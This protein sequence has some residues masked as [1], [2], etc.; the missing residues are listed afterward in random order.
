MNKKI[1]VITPVYNASKTLVRCVESLVFGDYDNLDIILI[2]DCS[3]D[4]S[5]QICNMLSDKYDNVRCFQNEKNS[6]VSYTRNQ[7]LNMAQGEYIL[8]VDSDDWVSGRYAKKLFDTIN[9]H[10]ND[11][12][13]CGLHFIDNVNDYARDYLWENATEEISIVEKK[14]FF[15]LPNEFLLQQLWNKIFRKDIIDKNHIQFDVNQSMGE[16]YQFVLEYMEALQCKRC[17]VINEPLYY[18]IRANNFSLMSK[19]G[20][21][22]NENEYLRIEKLRDICGKEDHDILE[23][24]KRSVEV[25]KN[26]YAYYCVHSKNMSKKEKIDFI[27]SVF[28]DKNSKAYYKKQMK[29]KFKENIINSFGKIKKNSAGLL[30]RAK[31]LKTNYLV[32]KEKS[33]LKVSEISII[34]QNCISGVFY[35]D[36]NIKFLSPTINLYFSCPDFVK[37]VLHMDYY[38]SLSPLMKWEE[39]YPV[40][41]LDDIKINFMHYAT[42]T[43]AKEK[44]EERK[45]R[46]N[47]DKMVI[48]C[49]DMEDFNDD[50]Y[51][52][53]KTIK[54]KKLLFTANK[55]YS[56]NAVFFEKYEIC[57]K[58]KD[59]IPKREFYKDDAI[60]KIINK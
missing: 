17:I 42:C 20:L 55:K 29:I 53:W 38:L 14:D 8:C 18:Y 40:G 33:K 5:W 60:F 52:A 58:V 26:N 24:Y 10:G 35:H 6:G 3:N 1:S 28:K 12:V 32:R 54:Y 39:E 48:L 7:G 31:R 45:K 41:Y 13:I 4:N 36:M 21:I 50:V 2:D 59:L 11:L 46:I 49:T 22:D 25:T 23:A 19:F 15:K 44:W 51:S 37:F 27:E 9:N 57:H 34:S 47:P 30:L 56:E 43:E 16:D